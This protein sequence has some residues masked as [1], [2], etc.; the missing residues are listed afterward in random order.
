MSRA[1]AGVMRG[2]AALA[3]SIICFTLSTSRSCS[4]EKDFD[5][6]DRAAVPAPIAGLCYQAQPMR[7][8]IRSDDRG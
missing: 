6:G 4:I 5:R 3:S 1:M 7:H 2:T 8:I